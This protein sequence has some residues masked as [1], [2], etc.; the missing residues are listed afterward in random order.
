[1]SFKEILLINTFTP[2]PPC[3][4]AVREIATSPGDIAPIKIYRRERVE[5]SAV[6]DRRLAVM[7]KNQATTTTLT[8]Y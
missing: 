6:S 4:T 8:S 5:S 1:M 3:V 7:K 2:S